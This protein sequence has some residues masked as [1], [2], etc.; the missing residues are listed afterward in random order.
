MDK[1]SSHAALEAI[2][3]WETQLKARQQALSGVPAAT[4]LLET[5]PRSWS[6][7]LFRSKLVVAA[8]CLAENEDCDACFK[9][10]RRL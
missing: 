3:G 5:T 1:F 10:L 7:K 4:C 6:R 2:P 9:L 8:M